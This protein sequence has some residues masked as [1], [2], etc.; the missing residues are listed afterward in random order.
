MDGSTGP[1][2]IHPCQRIQR[3]QGK[4][5]V[6]RYLIDFKDTLVEEADKLVKLHRQERR[7]VLAEQRH[8]ERK[9]R[10]YAARKAVVV[11]SEDDVHRESAILAQVSY[12]E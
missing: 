6:T 1:T 2:Y 3:S 12:T 7:F 9:H 5:V 8:A 11:Y 10:L 4:G